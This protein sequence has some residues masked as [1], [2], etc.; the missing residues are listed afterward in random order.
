M[1]KVKDWESLMGDDVGMT[2]Y[3]RK[4]KVVTAKKPMK[5]EDRSGG[6]GVTQGVMRDV[7]TVKRG[8]K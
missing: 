8:L 1:P 4:V 2:G 6:F 3:R 7:N 5:M